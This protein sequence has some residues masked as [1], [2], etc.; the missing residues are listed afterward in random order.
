MIKHYGSLMGTQIISVA[1]TDGEL[2]DLDLVLLPNPVVWADRPSPNHSPHL[3][4]GELVWLDARSIEDA[5][6]Q[7]WE[8]IKAAREAFWNAPLVTPYGTFDSHEKARS[9]IA[10]A[11]LLSQTLVSVGM[12]TDTVFT[13]ANNTTATLTPSQMVE[14]GLLLGQKVQNGF[15]TGRLRRGQIESPTVTREGLDGINWS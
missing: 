9:D 6:A 11:V 14:V 13:L 2:E 15:A 12:P 5:R 4:D 10:N 8:R 3:I 7:A 1:S